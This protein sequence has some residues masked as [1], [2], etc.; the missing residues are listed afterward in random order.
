MR[1]KSAA[2][3]SQDWEKQR[4]NLENARPTQHQNGR[5][6][7]SAANSLRPLPNPTKRKLA[8]A[9]DDYDEEVDA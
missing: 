1:I 4:A 2:E 3:M 7:G 5:I 6:E 8:M 9:A